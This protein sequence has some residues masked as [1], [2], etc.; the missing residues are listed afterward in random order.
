MASSDQAV[1]ITCS[2][3]RPRCSA[4]SSA[5]SCGFA[6][7]LHRS[8]A[9]DRR[10][11]AHSSAIAGCTNSLLARFRPGLVTLRHGCSAKA[12]ACMCSFSHVVDGKCAGDITSLPSDNRRRALVGWSSTHNRYLAIKRVVSVLDTLGGSIVI[13]KDRHWRQPFRLLRGSVLGCSYDH[14]D[15]ERRLST[16]EPGDLALVL[17]DLERPDFRIWPGSQARS[18]LRLYWPTLEEPPDLDLFANYLGELYRAVA[19][20]AV[21]EVFCFGGHG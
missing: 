9:A 1:T 20:G 21:V 12:S 11:V 10:A 2:G 3:L 7:L 16:D 8:G 13:T 5:S 19:R 15:R 18:C 4:S 6:Y 17:F 14:P